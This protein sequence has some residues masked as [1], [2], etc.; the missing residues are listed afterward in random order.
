MSDNTQD[1][2]DFGY[3]ELGIAAELLSAYRK[4][5]P[6][7]LEDGIAIEFNPISGCV[8][9]IDEDYTVGMMNGDDIEQWFNCPECGT[10]GFLQEMI[11]DGAECCHAFLMEAGL[12]EEMEILESKVRIGETSSGSTRLEDIVNGVADMLTED[13]TDEWNM[14]DPDDPDDEGEMA[15]IFE[16]ILDHLDDI[17]P[18]GYTFG[19]SDNDKL[20]YGFWKIEDD[21]NEGD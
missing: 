16:E 4:T 21:L 20:S 11:D 10:E 19:T 7:F 13:L 8:F 18:N 12:A 6:D 2:S 15:G 17:A 1:L 5:P 9:L 14:Y 3:R